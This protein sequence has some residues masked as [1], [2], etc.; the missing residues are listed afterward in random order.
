MTDDVQK[1]TDKMIEQV[2]KLL[3]VKEAELMAV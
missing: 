3:E 1:L 2:N